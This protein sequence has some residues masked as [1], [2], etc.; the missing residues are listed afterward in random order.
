MMERL[1]RG[2][3]LV[4]AEPGSSVQGST[5]KLSRDAA[6]APQPRRS[7][8]V[9]GTLDRVRRT[10]L[11]HPLWTVAAVAALV[12]ALQGVWIWNHRLLGA[13]DPD[14]SGYIATAFRYH[15]VLATDPLALPRAIGG[16]GNGPLI[17]LLSIPLI[18]LGPYDPRTVLLMQPLLMVVTAIASAG[19]AHRLAGA[20]AAIVTG[21]VFV[22]LPT[23]VFATQTYWLGLGAA[24]FMALAMWALLSSDRLT[25]RWTYA[26]GAFV[27]LMLLCRTM[28]AG[29]V[30]AVALAGLVM[31]GR[32]RESLI[33]LAKA[34]GT[35]IL[36]AGPWWFVA[37]E[38]IFDYLFSYGYGKRSR[39]FGEGG[40]TERFM[41]RIETVRLG[42]GSGDGWI[43][44]V[45][46]FSA[47]VIWRS[48][49]GWPRATRGAV[50][51]ASAIGVGLVA[52]ASTSNNGV[53]FELP[54][55]ALVVPLAVALGAKAPVAVRT[56]V[57]IPVLVLGVVQLACS[58]WIIGPE[59]RPIPGIA[60][61][62]RVSQYEFGFEQYDLR[63]G[64]YRR[65]ELEQAAAD[66]HALSTDV[67][68]E[69]RSLTADGEKVYTITGNFQMFNSNTV[70][71]VG[72]GR[73]WTPRLWIP[74][75]VGTTAQRAKWLTPTATDDAGN[76]VRD[77]QGKAVERVLV[78]ALHDLRLFTPDEEVKT[79]YAEALDAGWEPAETFAIPVGGEVVVMRHPDAP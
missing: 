6:V 76:V 79:F 44:I 71:L 28:T 50:A 29:Y 77:P 72:E 46:A 52:L 69:L 68:E 43:L 19:I 17:P 48:W 24:A 25:N 21:V 2:G 75:T 26:F 11:R 56:A 60:A 13:L 47:F 45:L 12:A 53:W 33:G 23:V 59:R 39:L 9:L 18:I 10:L 16:T 34:G 40:P 30:P 22:T 27:G 62:H 4:V 7:P 74:D 61:V 35:A 58:W 38:P 32:T 42:V 65:T 5:G 70:G 73:S 64:P 49:D 37:R 66:W 57:L 15:R 51:V 1:D 63:F 54:V 14:E 31:A 8:H 3:V 20:G 78:V 67:E 41:N 36:V 55:V